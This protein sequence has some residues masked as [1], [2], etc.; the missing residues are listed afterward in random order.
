MGAT[1]AMAQHASKAG[2]YTYS[3]GDQS[4][5]SGREARGGQA[6]GPGTLPAATIRYDAK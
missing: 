3:T 2:A 1:S 6:F 4:L 5:D